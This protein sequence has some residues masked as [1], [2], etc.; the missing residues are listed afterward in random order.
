MRP[1]RVCEL[2]SG[3][4]LV[5]IVTS[6][7]GAE[8]VVL[9]DYDPGALELIERNVLVNCSA[10]NTCKVQSFQWGAD[11]RLLKPPFDLALGADLLYCV[12]VVEPLFN[13]VSQLIRDGGTFILATS[14][15]LGES[16][17]CE[18]LRCV[19]KYR[20]K[21]SEIVSLKEGQCKIQQYRLGS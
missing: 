3:C 6:L 21:C 8:E 19:T 17:E 20:L 16:I 11:V 1:S 7:L 10:N 12:E 14:F 15:E 5:G 13:T 4:G 9:T 2:G 18:V